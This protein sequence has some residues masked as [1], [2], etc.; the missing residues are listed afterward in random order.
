MTLDLLVVHSI[1]G[2]IRSNY[3][4][5]NEN[6]PLDVSLSKRKAKNTSRGHCLC[7]DF[8]VLQK[9]TNVIEL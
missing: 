6:V 7:F 2:K 9:E 5:H 8:I 1:V 4:Y 3:I